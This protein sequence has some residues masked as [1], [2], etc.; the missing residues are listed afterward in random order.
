MDQNKS[1]RL[2]SPIWVSVWEDGGSGTPDECIC[3]LAAQYETEIA[4]ALRD[5]LFQSFQS[6][7]LMIRFSL[8]ENKALE[9]KIRAKIQAAP[10]SVCTME[11]RLYAAVDLELTSELTEDELDSFIQQV[12]TQFRDDWGA[13]FETIGI[14]AAEGGVVCA[15]LF[16]DG[17]SFSCEEQA[18]RLG[19]E[20]LK[21][22][23]M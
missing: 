23:G 11:D 2:T 22:P 7:D 1:I 13:E 19:Q 5:F 18:P 20:A 21:G 8:P 6:D 9:S 15:R 14:P 16:H 12:Q 10:L 3:D 4:H 17:L